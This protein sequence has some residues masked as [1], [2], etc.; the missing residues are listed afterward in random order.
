MSTS[1]VILSPLPEARTSKAVTN[2]LARLK[3]LGAHG[4]EL[5][6]FAEHPD[7]EGL[8]ALIAGDDEDLRGRLDATTSLITVHNEVKLSEDPNFVECLRFLFRRSGESLVQ[9][10]DGVAEVEIAIALLA[11]LDGVDGFDEREEA[12]MVHAR[13]LETKYRLLSKRWTT[14]DASWAPRAMANHEVEQFEKSGRLKLPPEFR[15]YLAIVGIGPGPTTTGLVALDE[16]PKAKTYAKT[17]KRA[18]LG[19]TV[20]LGNVDSETHHILVCDGDFSGTIWSVTSEELS[21]GPIAADFLSYVED[22]IGTGEPEPLLCPGCDVEL[23]VQDL[24][25]E[26]CQGCGARREAAAERSEASVAFENLAQGLLMGL[27]DAELLEIDD[28]SLVLPLITALSEYMSE[29]GHKWKSPD[30]A[31]ASIAGWL[32]HRDEVAELHGSNSDVARVFVAVG[33]S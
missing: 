2:C 33:K 3:A 19:K 31:A 18:K 10:P 11:N 26:Y 8:E 23:G 28:P 21:D 22:W 4:P 14:G 9:F 7:P 30:R 20:H 16:M 32:M 27:L 6:V 15:G 13:L 25:K 12:R 17:A 1:I 24:E 29:K 5:Q